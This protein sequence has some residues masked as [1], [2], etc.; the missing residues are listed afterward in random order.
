MRRAAAAFSLIVLIAGCYK[1]VRDPSVD[2]RRADIEAKLQ[3]QDKQIAE[4]QTRGDS[5]E[6]SL[7]AQQISEL[8]AKVAELTERVAKAPPPRRPTARQPDPALVYAVPLGNS[9]V[10]GSPKAKVTMVMAFEF[11]CPYCRKAWDTV[12]ALQKKY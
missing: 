12:D 11:A 4:L 9:P 5:T 1:T 2:R 10:I 8:A 3:E 7:L 6:L